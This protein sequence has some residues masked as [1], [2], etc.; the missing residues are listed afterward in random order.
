MKTA[1]AGLILLLS[2]VSGDACSR[3]PVA[4]GA[5]VIAAPAKIDQKL[6]NAAILAEINYV[7]CKA[8]RAALVSD[9]SLSKVAST[10]AKWMARARS[11]S[12]KSGVA[13]QSTSLARLKSSGIRFRAGSEN[14]G[15]LARFQIDGLSFRIKDAAT[16][17]FASNSGQT[18]GAHSYTTLA[19]KIVELWMESPAHRRNILDGKVSK[20]GSGAGFDP[21][22]PFCG[23]FYVSQTFAG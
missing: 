3:M 16:C 17:H 19:R 7:R 4:G 10:H 12:H 11:L 8:G 21:K 20:V 2:A 9:T 5:A 6:V 23:S 13:G 18:L 15:Y 1:L 14:I 22:A